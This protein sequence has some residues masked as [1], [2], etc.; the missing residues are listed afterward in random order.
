MLC[1]LH[2]HSIFSDGSCTPEEIIAQARELDLVVALTDHNTV[3]GLPAF[4]EAA[5][6]QGVTA[7]P[8]IEFST[9]HQGKELHL[10]GLFIGEAHYDTLERVAKEFHVLKE[11]RNMEMVERLNEAGYHIDYFDVKRRNPDG[12][13]NRAHVAAELMEHG[14]VSSITEAFSTLLAEGSGFYV[15][16]ERL[17]TAEG[18]RLLRRIRAVPVLAHPLQDLTPEALRSILPELVEAGLLAMETRHSSYDPEQM[19]TADA[20]AAEFGLLASG[21]SDFHGSNK[22]DIRLGSGKD[23]LAIPRGIYED[24]CRCRDALVREEG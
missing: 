9:G 4:L 14:Y 13:A 16:A 1:D 24:L 11:I 5:R 10:V 12:N 3:S 21:G 18:I 8:G 19:A 22:P 17:A 15:P 6:E 7:V 23:N 20:I 2:T